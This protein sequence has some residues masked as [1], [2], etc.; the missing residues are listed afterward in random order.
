MSVN[1][2]K[3]GMPFVFSNVTSRVHMSLS[4][5]SI[6]WLLLNWALSCL[7]PYSY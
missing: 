5:P 4:V 6:L 2:P 3:G 7:F 1:I